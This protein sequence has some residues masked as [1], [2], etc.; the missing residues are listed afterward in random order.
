MNMA[1]A[2]KQTAR[3][4]SPRKKYS[5]TEIVH[6]GSRL[7]LSGHVWCLTLCVFLPALLLV[8]FLP[9]T[10][11]ADDATTVRVEK[12]IG[13]VVFPT[14]HVFHDTEVGGLSA[15]SYDPIQK[16]YYLLSDD[17]GGHGRPRFYTARIDPLKSGREMVEFTGVTFLR[18]S[19]GGRIRSGSIDPE[20]I[21]FLQP[22]RLF[23]S[24][25]GM[26]SAGIAPFVGTYGPRGRLL[27]KLPLPGH[28]FPRPDEKK[29]TRDNMAFESLT[30]CPDGKTLYTATENALLQDGPKADLGQGSPARLLAYDLTTMQPAAEYLYR[31]EPVAEAPS[32]TLLYH[33]NGLVELLCLGEDK[34]LALE[35]SF[36]LSRGVTSR[37]F[38]V[39]PTGADDIR[40]FPSLAGNK[41]IRPVRKTLLLDLG[42]TGVIP[43]NIEG[44]ALGPMLSDHSRLLVM[45]SDNNFNAEQKTQLLFFSV[46]IQTPSRR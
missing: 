15:I 43:D 12:L 39:D 21:V 31:T 26:A 37:L 28:F 11:G 42:Q 41:S 3:F 8:L 27:Q 36:S 44:M 1:P 33:M 10:A 14:G 34:M 9:S 20:G 17:R 4:A 18:H 45:V 35:R 24:S 29:G 7:L 23:V 40:A 13:Q 5:A 2:Q 16:I 19:D 6:D 46:Q 32:T 25:E 30:L 38:L 22:D